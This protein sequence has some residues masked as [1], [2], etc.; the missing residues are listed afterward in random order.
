MSRSARIAKRFTSVRFPPA[1]LFAALAA[2]AATVT[3]FHLLSQTGGEPAVPLDDTFIHFQFARSFATL[4]PFVYSAAGERVA[5]ATSLLWPALLAPF[6]ALGFRELSLIWPAWALGWL[7]YGALGYETWRIAQ[8]LLGRGGAVAAAAMVCAF[9]PF[10]WFAASGMEVVPFAWL[11]VRTTRKSAEWY[12]AG[13]SAGTHRRDAIELLALSV[14][15]ALARPE[16]V[17]GS[18]T[19]AAAFALAPGHRFKCSLCLAAPLSTP[20]INLLFTGQAVGTT[21]RAKWLF[22]DPY[23]SGSAL[24][25]RI[26]EHLGILFGTL[27][28]GRVWSAI[29]MPQGLAPIF[30]LSLPALIVIGARRAA[31]FRAL[32]LVALGLALLVPAS[33]DSFLVNR[34][35]YLWPF[36][37]P[38][39]IGLAALSELCAGALS[40][41]WR[42]APKLGLLLSAA[43]VGAFAGHTGYTIEDVA[44]SA[45][46]IRRQQVSLGRWARER[47]PEGSRIGLN[48]A[49]AIAYLSNLSTFDVVGLTT[50]SEVEPW[51]AGPGSRFE[52]YE[53]LSRERLPTHFF[54]YPAWFDLD[55]LLGPCL[56]ERHVPGATILGGP[57]MVACEADYGL[58]ESGGF[59]LSSVNGDLIDV[60]D[61]AD[62]ESE[63]AHAYVLGGASRSDNRLDV[64]AGHADGMRAR[65]RLESFELEVAGGGTVVARLTAQAPCHATLRAGERTLAGAVLDGTPWQEVPFAL[66]ADLGR[67]RVTLTLHATGEF[68]ALHYWSLKP[69]VRVAR[70]EKKVAPAGGSR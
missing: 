30:W 29:F 64:H 27:L 20:A 50:A 32:A 36:A 63:R 37:V 35:R 7:A 65:R 54:V 8:R 69:P 48:D 3:T 46:A 45:D 49:G 1:A 21:T 19:A 66:P 26:T 2:A 39:L 56:T 60:L 16:G 47:L 28:D 14:A 10:L 11:L 23:L 25:D 61:V 6:Y 70:D 52:H 34:L 55:P 5:G 67:R 4:R 18:L 41:F 13:A 12:E 58:L 33:Y 43:L 9:G 17:V 24:A 22:H 68:S 51:R 62:L 31:R 15:C 38:W 40:R 44:A 59:P 53:R 42:G 57:T